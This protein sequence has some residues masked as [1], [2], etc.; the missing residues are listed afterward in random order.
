MS[1]HGYLIHLPVRTY[2]GMYLPLLTQVCTPPVRQVIYPGAPRANL[3]V[4]RTGG[5]V[6][7]QLGASLRIYP[8]SRVMGSTRES[9][10]PGT[11][12]LVPGQTPVTTVTDVHTSVCVYYILVMIRRVE[13]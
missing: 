4:F 3:Q 7:C 5:D 8:P 2:T 11:T 1:I 6:S 9:S 10:I 13:C 12:H